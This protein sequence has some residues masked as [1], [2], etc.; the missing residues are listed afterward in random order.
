M[1]RAI[2]PG[3]KLIVLQGGAFS[4]EERATDGLRGVD[5]GKPGQTRWVRLDDGREV[6]VDVSALTE[7]S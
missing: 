7:A 2:R 5:D 3:A 1:S 4:H 6:L